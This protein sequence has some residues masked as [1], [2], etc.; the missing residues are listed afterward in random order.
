MFGKAG[1]N[2]IIDL[3]FNLLLSFVVL[4]VL[5]FWMVTKKKDDEQAKNANNILITMRWKANNDMDLW[6]KLPDGR[7]VGYNK[8]D[9]PPA[10]LDVDVVNWRKYHNPDGSEYVI[11]DNEE[12]I[13]IRSILEGEYIVNVHYFNPQQVEPGTDTEVEI[14]I[15][16]VKKKNMLYAGKQII[17]VPRS[18]T[19]F[20]KFTVEKRGKGY[21]VNQVRTNRPEYFVG[22]E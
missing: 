12:I 3:L 8:R 7:H 19:H 4:F 17:S 1:R 13:T 21:T 22:K 6:L 20:V 14:L 15:Q 2:V 10:H 5:A 9:E 16:D 11:K 18:E